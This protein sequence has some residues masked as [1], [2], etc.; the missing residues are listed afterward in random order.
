MS[1]LTQLEKAW[2]ATALVAQIADSS[3]EFVIPALA[4]SAEIAE[5]LEMSE[6]LRAAAEMF[7][8]VKHSNWSLKP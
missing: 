6:E 7:S 5:K 4:K 2:L 3:G 1:E 8:A